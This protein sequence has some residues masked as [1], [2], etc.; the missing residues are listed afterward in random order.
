MAFKKKITAAGRKLTFKCLLAGTLLG[1]TPLAMAVPIIDTTGATLGGVAPFGET[2]TATYGQ[3]FTVTGPETRLDNFSFRLNDSVNP[4]FVDF[5]AYVYAWDGSKATGAQL[6][7]S[8]GLSTTNNGGADGFEQF[9]IDTGGLQL[10]DGNQYVAFFS[11]SDFFDGSFGTSSWEL[12]LADAY[13][14]GN[15]VFNN[16]GDDFSLLT[17][18]NWSAIGPRDTWFV[19]NFSTPVPEPGTLAL[20][21]AGL[22]GMVLGRR[23][24]A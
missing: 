13:A 1:A 18:T 23:R 20:L 10:A 2:N 8:S 22:A 4:D 7:A 16:N 21:G 3:T 12:S 17:T 19:A 24:K 15:F 9:T 14:D 6:F 5:A 11:A